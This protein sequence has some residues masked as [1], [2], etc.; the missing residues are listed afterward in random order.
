MFTFSDRVLR[1]ASVQCECNAVIT[2]DDHVH[3]T[4]CYGSASSSERRAIQLEKTPYT[5]FGRCP[6]AT[7]S[8]F[9]LTTTSTGK[10]RRT[11]RG[12]GTRSCRTFILTRARLERCLNCSRRHSIFGAGGQTMR[13]TRSFTPQPTEKTGCK[14]NATVLATNRL[15]RKM[16]G[17]AYD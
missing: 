8:S 1:C 5:R 3:R 11:R 17:I 10:E 15:N 16:H 9:G 7:W 12:A 6:T 13:T 14:D 2:D 4:T